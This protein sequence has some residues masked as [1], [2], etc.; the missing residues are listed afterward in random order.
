M[1]QQEKQQIIEA[2]KESCPYHTRHGCDYGVGVT[3]CDGDCS[4]C[5][6]FENEINNLNKESEHENFLE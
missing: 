3:D 6:K 1:T 4:Y 5:E 2:F